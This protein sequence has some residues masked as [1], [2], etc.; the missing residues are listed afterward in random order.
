MSTCSGLGEMVTLPLGSAQPVIRL[1]RARSESASPSASPDRPPQTLDQTDAPLKS[2]ERT[3]EEAALLAVAELQRYY[4][5]GLVMPRPPNAVAL[6]HYQRP[7]SSTA[8]QSPNRRRRIA[9]AKA[10]ED[11]ANAL[12]SSSSPRVELSPNSMRILHHLRAV[13]SGIDDT[14]VH[15]G[16]L[17]MVGNM[18]RLDGAA[19]EVGHDDLDRRSWKSDRPWATQCG[20]GPQPFFCSWASVLP[21]NDDAPPP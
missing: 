5:H 7:K 19:P 6:L 1:G 13:D 8:A 21:S 4:G 18:D 9:E 12:A 14:L 16:L 3:E 10:A 17:R 20:R 15:R 2:Q 11:T